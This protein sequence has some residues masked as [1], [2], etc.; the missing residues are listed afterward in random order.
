MGQVQTSVGAGALPET[1]D[2][3]GPLTAGSSSLGLMCH[4]SARGRKMQP[5][6]SP[7]RR[8]GAP[9]LGEQVTPEGIATSLSRCTGYLG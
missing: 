1:W 7:S 8:P 5:G 6:V 9:T 3:C 2:T 4:A